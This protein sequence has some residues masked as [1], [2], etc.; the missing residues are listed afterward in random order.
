MDDFAKI[1]RIRAVQI[2]ANKVNT[3]STSLPKMYIYL[4]LNANFQKWKITA[5]AISK[6]FNNPK[7]YPT[8]IS[9][10]PMHMMLPIISA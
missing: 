7:K 2:R 9:V 10:T 4:Y 8:T 3:I 5:L 1:V 6:L